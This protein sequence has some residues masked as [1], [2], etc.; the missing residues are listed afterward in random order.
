MKNNLCFS[1]ALTAV[2]VSG[3]ASMPRNPALAEAQN[4]YDNAR[5]NPMVTNLAAPELAIAGYYLNKADHA[6]R[7][8][9]SD[10]FVDHLA[11]LA[12]QQA[13]IAEQTATWKTAEL[14]ANTAAIKRNLAR[15]LAKKA[16]DE[17]ARRQMLIKQHSAG[18][19]AIELAAA[20]VN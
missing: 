6:F 18:L 16:A 13:A 8:H 14:L 20:G 5:T 17:A 7:E 4:R 1:M 12:K 9:A 19:H 11:Y 3:C 15:R 2:I 10:D